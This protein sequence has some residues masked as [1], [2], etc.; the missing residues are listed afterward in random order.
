M[1]EIRRGFQL[2]ALKSA[3]LL[4]LCL[5]LTI[6]TPH[7]FSSVYVWSKRE[8]I[9]KELW[10]WLNGKMRVWRSLPREIAG[11]NKYFSMTSR[12]FTGFTRLWLSAEVHL[13]TYT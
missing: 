2:I 13:Q 5:F 11:S 8:L 7:Y 12:I 10:L 6:A 9:I 1:Y 3:L 4:V